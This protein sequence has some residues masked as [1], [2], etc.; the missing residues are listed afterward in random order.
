M[1]RNVV[2]FVSDALRYDRFP[3]SLTG[4]SGVI[5][6]LAPSLHT[7]TSFASILSGVSPENH[8]VSSFVE[9]L[10]PEFKTGFEYFENAGFYDGL[11]A[12]AINEHVAK[13]EMKDL[14]DMNQPFILVER[15]LDTHT[16]Y[17]KI[18]HEREYSGNKS[19]RDY[20]EKCRKGKLSITQE[21]S[22]GVKSME[23]YVLGAIEEL[24]EKGLMENT[25]VIITSDHDDALGERF[26]GRR[27]EHNYQPT[28][29]IA[30]IPA[31]LYNY[32]PNAESMRSIDMM[33]TALSVT[34]KKPEEMDVRSLNEEDSANRGINLMEDLK[35]RFGAVGRFKD[36][37]EPTKISKIEIGLKTVYGDLKRD[38]YRMIG[39]PLKNSV[40]TC[41]E[42]KKEENKSEI[43]DVEI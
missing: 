5:E 25:L 9:G 11:D 28:K 4:E 32:D 29:E 33:P 37:W 36:E 3:E 17:G 13:T 14:Q 7:P 23:K 6:T 22:K 42:E 2:I 20:I 10:N 40:E 24:E 15:M 27:F 41:S 26:L 31:A 30:G 8:N 1:F 19:G 34:G 39:K 43:K 38:V 16:P 35:G 18:K 12:S 21:Y